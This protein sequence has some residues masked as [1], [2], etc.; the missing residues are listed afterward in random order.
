VKEFGDPLADSRFKK[1]KFGSEGNETFNFYGD[2][3]LS[4]YF[5]Q[6]D[7]MDPIENPKILCLCVSVKR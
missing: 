4:K 3:D 6:P 2:Y 7:S 1:T 5:E